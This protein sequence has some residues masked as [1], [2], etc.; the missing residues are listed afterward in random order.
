[1]NLDKT[2]VMWVGKER[3]ELNISDNGG[4]DVEVQRR[5]QAGANAWRNVEGVMVVRKIFR[6]LKGKVLDSCVVP[7]STYALQTLALSELHQHKLQVF[8][9]NWIRRIAGVKRVGRRRMKDLRE[10]VG[11]KACIVGK[12]VKS[13]MKWAGHMVRMKDDKLTKRSEKK[14][15]ECF[16]KRGR[17]Q[18]RWEDCVKRDLRKAEEEEKWREKANNR[19]Q[20]NQITKVT[21][22]RSDQ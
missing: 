20:W 3:E 16:R 21:V 1:M 6:K 2:E 15:Q 4:V 12:I 5:I 10:E 14:K 11:T 19:D 7:A 17:P 13:R 8:E 18:L 22:L 9:N